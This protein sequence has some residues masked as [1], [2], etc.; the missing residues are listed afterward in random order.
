[1]NSW[2]VN[3]W[4]ILFKRIKSF[5]CS[6]YKYEMN[7]IEGK[8]E[9]SYKYIREKYIQTNSKNGENQYIK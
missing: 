3:V 5:I 7:K 9:I 4:K 2:K 1:M 6:E 8:E